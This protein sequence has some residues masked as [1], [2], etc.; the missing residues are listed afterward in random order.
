MKVFEDYAYYYNAFYKDKDYKTEAD[1][2]DYLLKKYGKGVKDIINFGC[3]T[4]RH[5]IELVKRGY[6]CKGLDLSPI[7]IDIAKKQSMEQD[8]KIDFEVADVRYY[9]SQ[10][11]YDAVISL[12]HV[13]SYQS[14]NEDI[15]NAF[16]AARRVLDKGGVFIFDVWYGPGVLSDKPCVRVKEAEDDNNRLIRIARP[17]MH[18]KENM[19]DVYYEV[20]IINKETD[21]VRT[22]NEVH[23]MRYFFRLELEMLLKEANFE[24]LDNIDCQSLADTDYDSWTSYFIARA[25]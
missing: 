21:K 4:G 15:L 18:D 10:E 11:Q 1:H 2:I 22:I 19:V 14:S 13:M 6:T 17:V 7:M 23:N 24:V 8:C 20:L 5:D 9:T 3:G 25:K 16:R 12:F